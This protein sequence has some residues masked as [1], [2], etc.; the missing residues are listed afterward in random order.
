MCSLLNYCQRHQ[1]PGIS[2]SCATSHSLQKFVKITTYMLCQFMSLAASVKLN[3]SCLWFFCMY[4]YLHIANWQFYLKT[5]LSAVSKISHWFL[6]C[7]ALSC[8]DA[9]DKLQVLYLS[10]LKP[11]VQKWFTFSLENYFGHEFKMNIGKE[12]RRM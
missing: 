2:Y 7:P 1:S 9:G 8:K 6:V 11:K 3:R 10:Q 5:Q 4:L 12:K